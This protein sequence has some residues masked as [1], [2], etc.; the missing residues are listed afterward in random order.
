MAG[1]GTLGCGNA[2]NWGQAVVQLVVIIQRIGGA[3]V[4]AV[5]CGNARNWEAEGAAFGSGNVRMGGRR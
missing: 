1:G 3:G 5:G 4:V 2:R